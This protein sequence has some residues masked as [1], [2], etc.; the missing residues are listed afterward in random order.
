[1]EKLDLH[2]FFSLDKLDIIDEKKIRISIFIAEVIIG[3]FFDCG[4]KFVDELLALNV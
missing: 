2:L 1:M 4:D 3:G